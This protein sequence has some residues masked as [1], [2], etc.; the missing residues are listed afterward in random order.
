MKI[1]I[2][3]NF[4]YQLKMDKEYSDDQCQQLKSAVKKLEEQE[5]TNKTKLKVEENDLVK[6]S[7]LL[8]KTRL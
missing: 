4:N 8:I 7:E 6:N 5:V 2:L 3:E 1:S